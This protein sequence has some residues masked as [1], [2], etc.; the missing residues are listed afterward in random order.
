MTLEEVSRATKIKK[1]FLEALEKGDYQSLPP[2]TFI[3][4]FIKSYASFLD[5]PVEKLLP[6]FRREYEAKEKVALLPGSIT[7]PLFP[8]PFEEIQRKL[9]FCLVFVLILGFFLFLARGFLL[10]PPLEVFKP[11][12]GLITSQLSIEVA[13]KTGRE[14]YLTVNN[15]RV[16]TENG[17]FSVWI[18]LEKGENKIV[19]MARNKLGR[20]RKIIRTVT[21]KIGT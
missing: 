16:V 1:E 7:T 12:E 2:P 4:G 17:R 19:V 11:K 18:R 21:R 20:T 3:K 15:Q 13:G 5:L 8:S 10:P 14:V 6:L 9:F